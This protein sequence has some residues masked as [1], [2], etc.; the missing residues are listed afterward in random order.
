MGFILGGCEEKKDVLL[1]RG[2]LALVGIM[3][4]DIGV[5]VKGLRSMGV[6]VG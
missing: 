5:F 3:V 2:R 1:G 6:W 4:T